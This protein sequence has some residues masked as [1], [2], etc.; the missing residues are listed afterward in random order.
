LVAVTV[1]LFTGC[2]EALDAGPRSGWGG[3]RT[4]DLRQPVIA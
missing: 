1:V 4:A 2:A 3:E